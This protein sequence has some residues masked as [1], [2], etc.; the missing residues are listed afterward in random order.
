MAKI[1]EPE[2]NSSG[3]PVRPAG[4]PDLF[5]YRPGYAVIEGTAGEYSFTGNL[6]APITSSDFGGDLFVDPKDVPQLSD[7]QIIENTTYGDQAGNTSA[8]IVLKILA[9]IV[10]TTIVLTTIVTILVAILVVI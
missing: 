4:H 8:K 2:I 1:N 10:L 3:R 9:T 6:L 5:W 7:I